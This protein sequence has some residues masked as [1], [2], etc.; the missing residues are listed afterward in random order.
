MFSK[1][2]FTFSAFA[3]AAAAAMLAAGGAAMAT[4]VISDTFTAADGTAIPGR[5][6]SPTDLP[7]S[8]WTQGTSNYEN[9]IKS[10]T[11]VLGASTTDTIALNT[12]TA[13]YSITSYTISDQFNLSND[14]GAT[15]SNGPERGAFLGFF[16]SS[17][18]NGTYTSI[19]G[20]MIISYDGTATAWENGSQ[21]G[22][23]NGVSI[24]NF[25]AANNHTLSMD[26]AISGTNA[27]FSNFLLDGTAL[28]TNT[29]YPSGVS[30]TIS[31]SDLAY[32][33]F[34]NSSAT[35]G[36]TATFDNFLLTTPTV[37]PEPA[38]VG[39][40]GLGAMGLLLTMRRRRTT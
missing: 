7:G 16:N 9:D 39:L 19:A 8:I 2:C 33:A 18:L 11:A 26:V 36:N 40:L 31:T 12:F 38:T 25:N 5:T 21:I 30:F 34:Y 35:A 13:T 4:T 20:G 3:A 10:D 1:S 15:S 6:P 29:N 24:S 28:P 32:P 23:Y 14:S 27:T 22:N 37:I 17:D